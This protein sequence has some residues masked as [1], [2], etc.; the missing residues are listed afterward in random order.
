MT[1][2]YED[3]ITEGKIQALEQIASTHKERLDN[4]ATRLRI[5]EKIVWGVLGIVAF[6]QILPVLKAAVGVAG[7]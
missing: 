2:T 7:G 6:L 5:V 3:G 4:H 1:K